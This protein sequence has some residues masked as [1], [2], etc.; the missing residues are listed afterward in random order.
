MARRALDLFEAILTFDFSSARARSSASS[1]NDEDDSPD[2]IDDDI[3]IHQLPMTWV[4]FRQASVVSTPFAIFK[5]CCA[6][7]LAS[8]GNVV[9]SAAKEAILQCGT[10]SLKV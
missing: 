5:L 2:S 3:S 6:L 7:I 1:S 10:C 4:L 8:P 9:L